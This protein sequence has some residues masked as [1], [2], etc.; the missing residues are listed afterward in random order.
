MTITE[1]LSN[2]EKASVEITEFSNFV[3]EEQKKITKED[4]II[5]EERIQAEHEENLR[6]QRLVEERR[7]VA[8]HTDEQ[9]QF[10]RQ[11]ETDVSLV[12]LHETGPISTG[13]SGTT[14][15]NV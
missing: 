7:R 11:P 10:M 6:T 12:R 1:N 13:E 14:I 4:R 9:N 3:T 15:T 2:Y 8:A 5:E